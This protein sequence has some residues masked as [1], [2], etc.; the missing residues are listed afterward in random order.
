MKGRKKGRREKVREEVERKRKK[1]K[2]NVVKGL[3]GYFHFS[4]ISSK[5]VKFTK[6]TLKVYNLL[7]DS[8]LS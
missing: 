3:F 8:K 7:E 5:I 1:M 4:P 6:K 2:K